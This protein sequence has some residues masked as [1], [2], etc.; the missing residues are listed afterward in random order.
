[1]GRPDRLGTTRLSGELRR[2]DQRDTAFFRRKVRQGAGGLPHA[3]SDGGDPLQRVFF[4]GARPANC[5]NELLAGAVDGPVRPV[6]TDMG[7]PEAAA[8]HVLEAARFFGADLAGVAPLHAAFAYHTAGHENGAAADRAGQPIELTHGWAVAMAFEMD[9]RRIASSPSF[10]DAAEVGWGYARAAMTAVSLAAYLRE[11]GY[12]ARAHV[13]RDEQVLHI[14]LAVLAGLGELA[15]NG[16]LITARY[17]P[18]VRL[19]TV[20]TDLPLA[21]SRPMDLGVRRFCGVCLKCAAACPSRSVPSG[22]PVILRGAEKWAVAGDTCLDFW[23]AAPDRWCN[24]SVC[25]K[26]CPWNKPD[27]WWHALAAA[28][29][30]VLPWAAR[31]LV[32]LD[33]LLFGRNPRPRIRWLGYDNRP[34]HDADR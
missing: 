24:C 15:R 21:P 18:R 5:V 8:A 20:T 4:G 32:W 12:P 17:G 1:M 13:V 30:G 3:G 19:A 9:Y 10:I 11:L 25:I 23:H 22:A 27:S 28:L 16:L 7:T 14:P 29:V 2:M 31:P 33:D 34:G 6:P 26:V